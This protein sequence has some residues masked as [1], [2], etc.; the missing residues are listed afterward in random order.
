MS[1]LSTCN[2]IARVFVLRAEACR[3]GEATHRREGRRGRQVGSAVVRV[4]SGGRLAGL[5]ER[6]AWD[7]HP[8]RS[9]LE[10]DR[11]GG[12]GRGL[13]GRRG[14]QPAALPG[15]PP[16]PQSLPERKGVHCVST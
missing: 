7:R 12:E 5:L 1:L 15:V 2:D 3:E 14:R 13:V 4:E 6:R 8:E 10:G 9:R 11:G 16:L